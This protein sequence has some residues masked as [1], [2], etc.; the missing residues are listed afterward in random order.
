MHKELLAQGIKMSRVCVC[1]P[2][3]TYTHIPAYRRDH[4]ISRLSPVVGLL[5]K[6]KSKTGLTLR[7]R[8]KELKV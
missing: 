6:I 5:E 3:F 4:D 7:R 1:E 8:C 2:D